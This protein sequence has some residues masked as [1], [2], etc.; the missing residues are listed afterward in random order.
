MKGIFVP[1]S[2]TPFS[3]H[4]AGLVPERSGQVQTKP[5]ASGEHGRGQG[6]GRV[7]HAWR[8][9]VRTRLGDLQRLH[10]PVQHPDHPH[11]PDEPH[12]AHRH[13]RTDL[14]AGQPGRSRM[15]ESVAEHLN[16]PLLMLRHLHN[17]STATRHLRPLP[18]KASRPALDGHLNPKSCSQSIVLDA[19]RRSDPTSVRRVNR[20]T[21]ASFVPSQ[22]WPIQTLRRL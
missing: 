1:L 8:N 10:E 15:P 17:A 7:D 18:P 16:Q 5:P 19:T 20:S 21:W 2:F 13:L 14:R 22:T 9:T 12:N 11:G 4:L 6:F 3:R